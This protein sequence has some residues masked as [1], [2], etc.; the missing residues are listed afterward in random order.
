MIETIISLFGY[1]NIA[2]T[3]KL[4]MARLRVC[5]C[6]GCLQRKR[7]VNLLANIL[8]ESYYFVIRRVTL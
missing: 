6:Y 7:V 5:F 3:E 8:Y 1:N 2:R 4:S